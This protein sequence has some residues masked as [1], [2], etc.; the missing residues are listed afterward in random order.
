MDPI[1]S[2]IY[3]PN[4]RSKSIS[5]FL[6]DFW[7][8]KCLNTGQ[9]YMI[10]VPL[11]VFKAIII[12]VYRGSTCSGNDFLQFVKLNRYENPQHKPRNEENQKLATTISCNGCVSDDSDPHNYTLTIPIN[13]LE[14]FVKTD[15]KNNHICVTLS[16][17]LI[18]S[19]LRLNSGNFGICYPDGFYL[20]LNRSFK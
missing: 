13:Q 8:G 16:N 5:G 6:F 7:K 14:S 2:E 3:N 18:C 11:N 12:R 1:H 4:L 15:T 20:N 9:F 19:M 17:W 10:H